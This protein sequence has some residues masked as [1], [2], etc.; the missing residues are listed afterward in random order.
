[1]PVEEQK[2]DRGHGVIGV[3]DS[4]VGGLSVLRHIRARL[5]AED[6]LYLADAAF[7]PYG[8]RDEEVLRQRCLAIGKFLAGQGAKALVVACNTAT[9]AGVEALRERLD[10]P[11]IGM[12]PAIKPAAQGSLRGVVG[13]LATHS[14][15]SSRRFARLMQRFTEHADFVLQPCPGLVELI[16]E[17]E[18]ESPKLH[19]LLRGFLEPVLARGAD[20]IVLGCTHYPFVIP[21]IRQIVGPDIGILDTGEAVARELERQLGMHGLARRGGRGSARFLS[22]KLGAD[23]RE[24]FSRFWGS[25]VE[26]ELVR[27]P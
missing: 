25:P 3:F 22:T 23:S 10:L 9:A 13:V 2:A 18:S 26:P 19:D 12:E 7:L 1:M 14:T 4:G 17:G 16:E 6:L 20:T 24:V 21:L 8:G 11:I 15:L 27:L 5:P